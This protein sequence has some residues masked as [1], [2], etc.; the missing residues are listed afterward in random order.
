MTPDHY[1][2]AA[3]IYDLW[4]RLTESKAATIAFEMARVKPG[5]A[6]LEVAVGTGLFF[7]RMVAANPT[8][9]NEGVELSPAMLSRA[10]ARLDALGTDNYHLQSGDAR[11]LPFPEATFDLLVNNYMLDLLP[12]DDFGPLLAGFAR[13]L[14][15]NGRLVLS[16]MAPGPHWYHRAWGALADSF[17]AL[18][19]G[20]RP[21]VI[22]SHLSAAGF[23]IEQQLF[24]SQNTF[25]SEV[26]LARKS[27]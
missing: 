16:T 10:Q 17:P 8:G 15:P 11:Q 9:R 18:L 22:G 19:T 2:S 13:V 20:C 5:Q 26:T 1:R 24:V 27:P 25:P 4:A 21:V 23:A 14:K 7:A 6:L 12:E 3:P